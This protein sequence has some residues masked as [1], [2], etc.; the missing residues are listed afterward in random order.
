MGTCVVVDREY[1]TRVLGANP[2]KGVHALEPL[3]AL[4]QQTGFPMKI[5]E[6]TQIFNDAEVHL[7][8]GDLWFCIEGIARLIYGGELFNAQC[9]KQADGSDNPQELFAAEIKNG[10]EIELHPGDWLWVPAGQPHQHGS[11]GTARLGII[12]IPKV[13]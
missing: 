4:A 2:E 10:T 1:I 6:D 7:T 12:K 11:T 3:A 9:R 8:E 13:A 5:L